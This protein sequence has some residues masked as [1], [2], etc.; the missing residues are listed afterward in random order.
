MVV[1]PSRTVHLSGV[2]DRETIVD[3]LDAVPY[4]ATVDAII[5]PSSGPRRMSV[6]AQSRA[7]FDQEDIAVLH[8]DGTLVLGAFDLDQNPSNSGLRR[9]APTMFSSARQA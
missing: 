3:G 2:S 8:D 4:P 1:G 5:T 7:D 9:V 6:S